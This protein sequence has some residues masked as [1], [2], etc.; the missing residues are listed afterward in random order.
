[1]WSLTTGHYALSAHAVVE[2][3]NER[4]HVLGEMTDRLA[5]RFDITHV[6][7]QL[8]CRDRRIAEPAHP[9]H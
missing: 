5:T 1:V 8:E 2:D 3:G 4:E 9:A 7:I 6:T